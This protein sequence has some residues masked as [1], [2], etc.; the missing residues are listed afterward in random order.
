MINFYKKISITDKEL[1]DLYIKDCKKGLRYCNSNYYKTYK[2]YLQELKT[3]ENS[4]KIN[5]SWSYKKRIYEFNRFKRKIVKKRKEL[6]K[7]LSLIKKEEFKSI[8]LKK[9]IKNIGIY[10]NACLNRNIIYI[11]NQFYESVENLDNLLKNDC[12]IWIDN[13]YSLNHYLNF[14]SFIDRQGEVITKLKELWNKYPNGVVSK[15]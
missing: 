12:L 7:T 4:L 11:E 3:N 15:L 6:E 13:F 8:F 2:E 14:N 5:S 9:V 10:S 1:I